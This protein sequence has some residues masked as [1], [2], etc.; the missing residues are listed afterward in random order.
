MLVNT[1]KLVLQDV[2][3]YMSVNILKLQSYKAFNGI[4][5]MF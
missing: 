4:N 3:L 2:P 5:E 1:P